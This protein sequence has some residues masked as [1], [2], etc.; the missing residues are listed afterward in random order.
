[1][2]VILGF[3]FFYFLAAELKRLNDSY[4]AEEQSRK[5]KATKP[6]AS[7]RQAPQKQEQANEWDYLFEQIKRKKG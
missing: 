5:P 2:S 3:M 1:V 4:N 6:R 7:P